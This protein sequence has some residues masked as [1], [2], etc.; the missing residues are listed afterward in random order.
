MMSNAPEA[1]QAK[2]WTEMQQHMDMIADTL[3]SGIAKQFPQKA[4]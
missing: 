4:N 3:A 1:E 2:A